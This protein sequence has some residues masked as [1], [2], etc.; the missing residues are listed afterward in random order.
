MLRLRWLKHEL[1]LAIA[2]ML[3]VGAAAALPNSATAQIATGVGLVNRQVGGVAIDAEGVLSNIDPVARKELGELRKKALAGVPVDL[4]DKT[5]LRMVSLRLLDQ[6]LQ[7]LRTENKPLTDDV[8]YLA[9]L[10]RVRYIFLDPANQDIV[11][12]G[13]A[14]GWKSDA[15]GNVVGETTGQPVLH[16]DDLLVALRSAD[17]A[18]NGGISCSINPTEEGRA[19]LNQVM[20]T[21]RT[22]G[23]PQ[24]TF[25]EYENALGLQTIT[26]GGVPGDSHFARVLVAADYR[27]KRLAMQLDPSPIHGL[28]NNLDKALARVN[29]SP[30]WWLSPNYEALQKDPEGL[31]WELSGVGVKCLTEEDTFADDGKQTGTVKATPAAQRWAD[32]FTAKYADLAAKEPVFAE[33]RNC[34]DLAVIAALIQKEDFQ[35]QASCQLGALLSNAE[36]PIEKYNVPTKVAAKASAVKKGRNWIIATSGGVMIQPWEMIQEAKKSD[37]VATV[38]TKAVT[39]RQG[40]WYW[41]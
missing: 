1:K 38:R 28:V 3:V 26:V 14:E 25:A 39:A 2:G 12:A 35:K 17:Q 13:P 11:L 5:E 8:R 36:T 24:Q 29:G 23:N 18:R 40:N 27:M 41:D 16:L 34:I 21:K 20:S 4:D 15:L 33:L 7:K 19:R 32:I 30:R 10:Q 9:G 31:A 22:I 37:T 6:H